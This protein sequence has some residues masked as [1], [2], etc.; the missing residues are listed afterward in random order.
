VNFRGLVSIAA[1]STAVLG[2]SVVLFDVIKLDHSDSAPTFSMAPLSLG[3]PAAAATLRTRTLRNNMDDAVSAE[4]VVPAITVPEP[5]TKS[6]HVKSGA[7]LSGLL[8][9]AGVGRVEAAEI[10]NSFSDAFNPRKIRAGQ[11]IDLF[12]MASTDDTPDQFAG[13]AYE[14]TPLRTI[15]L[16]RDADGFVAWDE[17]KVLTTKNHEAHG[18]I[19]DSLYMAGVRAGLPVPVLLELIRAYSWDVDFQRS[20]RKGDGFA[21]L[22]EAR[23]DEEGEILAYGDILFAELQL[24]GDKLP[25]FQ[26]KTSDGTID[27]FDDKGRSAKKTLMRTPIDGARLSSGFGNRKHPVLGYNKMHKGVDFAAARGTPIY[28]AGDGAIDFAGRNGGYGKFVRIRHNGEYSTAYA[29]MK[30]IASGMKTGKR[31]RQGDVIG[32]VGTT[33]R[34]TGPHLHYEI[35]KNGVQVNPMKVKMPSGKKLKGT[36]LARFEEVAEQLSNLYAEVSSDTSV[37][38]SGTE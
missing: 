23:H 20:I 24:S 15:R 6:I 7:T 21:V 8:T 34:S 16:K 25:I 18:R 37:A 32:Y 10:V 30:S 17:E 11:D 13:L 1:L 28:A 12:F 5:Y 27:Y 14:P 29:H 33:G 36:E 22:Y 31:V 9:G 19:D 3:N 38:R 26:F 4:T 2:A 35:L